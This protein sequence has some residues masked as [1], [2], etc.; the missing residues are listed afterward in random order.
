MDIPFFLHG[1]KRP[2][3]AAAGF[4][5][6]NEPGRIA[7]AGAM[8]GYLRNFAH[9]GEPGC[10]GAELPVWEPWSNDAAGP[11]HI[12]FDADCEKALVRMSRTELGVDEVTAQFIT[13]P[14]RARELAAAT[15]R[16]FAVSRL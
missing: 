11:K 6:D 14:E 4:N 5:E 13:L 2:V 12:I 1:G 3:M 8:M 10:P 15:E 16:S 7:L 9:T